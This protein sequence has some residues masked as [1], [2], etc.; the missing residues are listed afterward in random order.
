M[1]TLRVT[2]SVFCYLLGFGAIVYYMD[3][4]TGFLVPKTINSG[5]PSSLYSA[6]ITDLGL[7][8]IFA[9]QHSVMARNSFKNWFN[10]LFPK[11][12]GRSIYI[13]LT[14]ICLGILI[15]FWQP[16]PLIIYDVSET[17][18]GNILLFLY[19]FGWAIGILSSFEIDHLAL[20]GVKQALKPAYQDPTELKK[21]FF[22]RIVRHPIYT[23]WLLIHWMTPVMTLGH[24]LLAIGMTIY[25]YV[26]LVFEERD[27]IKHF[28][29]KYIHYKNTT[30]KVNP[31]LYPVKRNPVFMKVV[32]GL[33]IVLATLLLVYAVKTVL[34]I[35]DELSRTKSDDPSV[36]QEAVAQLSQ[37]NL[38]EEMDSSSILFVG[39][40]SFRFWDDI[41]SD[42]APAKVINNGFGGAKITDVLEYQSQLI[43]AFQ[44]QRLVLFLGSNELK[45][46]ANDKSPEE[47]LN[48]Y[49]KLL[50]NIS[51]EHPLCEIYILP[52]T[53][54]P[55][56]REKWPEIKQINHQLEKLAAHQPQLHFIACSQNFLTKNDTPDWHLFNWDGIHLN[57]LGY[58]VWAESLKNHLQIN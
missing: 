33:A 4:F 58:Q 53:P 37:T 48:H 1:K 17:W 41:Q 44:P 40:S 39:S 5:N 28:G 49:Q 27:L 35:N 2:F 3:F 12:I 55:A 16:I 57:Q 20:F 26:A 21:P 36:W 15:W 50:T 6:L 30:P 32:H 56:N 13:L 14:S 34:W 29:E 19:Y 52:V 8:L 46:A 23:G 51:D 10:T 38:A 7:I 11:S 43:D 47:I 45:G 31:L 25:I 24:L 54:T 42:L 22:Y 18:L 9:L